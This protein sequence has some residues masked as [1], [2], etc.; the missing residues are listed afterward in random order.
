MTITRI[1]PDGLDPMSPGPEHQQ[2][3][4]R[5]SPGFAMQVIAWIVGI[6]MVYGAVNTR[7]TVLETKNADTERRLGSIESKI[8]LLLQ[9]GK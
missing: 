1:L 2:H 7:V 3:R 5:I 8:D 6:V 9:R 4:V